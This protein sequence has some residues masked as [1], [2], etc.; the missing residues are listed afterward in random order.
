MRADIDKSVDTMLLNFPR[1]IGLRRHTVFDR[2]SYDKYIKTFNGK[3]SL[4]TSLYSYERVNGRKLDVE[5]V[6][7]D[8]GWWDFDTTEEYSMED[9]KAD[10]GVLL[11]RLKGD[12]RIVATGRGFHVHELFSTPVKGLEISKH[13]ERYQ[14][15]MAKG[16]KTLDGVGH[17]KKLT[18]IPDTW[19]PKRGRWCVNVHPDEF[20]NNPMGYKI[21]K[22]PISSLRRFDPFTGMK[23]KSEFDIRHWIKENPIQEVEFAKVDASTISI[24]DAMGIPL[25]NCLERAIQKENPRHDI[26]VALAQFL[27]QNLRWFADKN[28]MSDEQMNKIENQICDYIATLNWRDYHPATTRQNVR[29]IINTYNNSPSPKWYMSKGYCDGG[30]CWFC[31]GNA[32]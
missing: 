27:S 29:Y 14:R 28:T 18:R 17:P 20:K 1:E 9:V 6:V 11:T 3:T 25:P 8:R 10:V 5:S 22:K 2:N 13:L 30:N 26:R 24:G 4:Y 21:H 16:L 23:S 15:S 32:R 12:I 31:E 7:M 19:N